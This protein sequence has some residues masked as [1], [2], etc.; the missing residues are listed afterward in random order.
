MYAALTDGARLQSFAQH[1]QEVE[2]EKAGS[3]SWED[4]V[5]GEQALGLLAVHLASDLRDVNATGRMV[6]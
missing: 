2:D 3:W 1:V 5:T 4:W 6:G